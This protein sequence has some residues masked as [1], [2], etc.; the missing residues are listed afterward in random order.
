MPRRKHQ[1]RNAQ[2]I[3]RLGHLSKQKSQTMT[4]KNLS[5]KTQ[6]TVTEDGFIV[7]GVNILLSWLP[8]WK[9]L[10]NLHRQVD[11][12]AYQRLF[13]AAVMAMTAQVASAHH[14]GPNGMKDCFQE[15]NSMGVAVIH[16]EDLSGIIDT[17]PGNMS[18]ALFQMA[19][20]GQFILTNCS[21]LM[22]NVTTIYNFVYPAPSWVDRCINY[23]MQTVGH[24]SISDTFDVSRIL[25]IINKGQSLLAN[26]S[27]QAQQQLPKDDGASP[28]GPIVGT[29]AVVGLV[30]A[31]AGYLYH[32]HKKNG[33]LPCTNKQ[34]STSQSLTQTPAT[35]G[36]YSN[37]S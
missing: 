32:Y 31:A 27:A 4:A 15:A 33:H 34:S 24:F 11:T 13:Y 9:N 28:A 25:C 23:T 26:I 17:F 14:Y 30:A 6:F 12:D 37:L 20:C 21:N 22:Q 29:L 35:R 19:E 1:H 8:D 7:N 5:E 16:T 3:Q 18:N 36:G 10:K 2:A